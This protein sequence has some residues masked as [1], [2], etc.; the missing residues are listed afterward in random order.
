MT[1]TKEQIDRYWE[2]G[3]IVVEG[4]LSA[5]EVNELRRVTDDLVE[6]SRTVS[7]HDET[8]DLEPNHSAAAPRVRRIKMPQNVHPAYGA[9]VRHEGLL[10]IL[11]QIIGP[12]IR[13][14]NAKLNMKAP[15]GGAAVEWHQD[16]AFY[17]HTNTDL[18]AVGVMMDDCGLENGP[19]LCMPGSH[20]GPIHDHHVDGVFSGAIDPV[21]SGLDF[22]RA[23][24]CTGKAGSVSIHH[25]RMIHGSAVNTSDR[26]RRLLLYQYCAADAWPLVAL[27]QPKD[28]DEWQALM[29]CGEVDQLVPR[30]EVAP[31]RLP[32][33]QPK[34]RGSIYEVQRALKHSYFNVPAAARSA[35]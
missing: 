24:A 4:V 19:L 10:R 35:G 2:D 12:A 26:P 20:K 6:K 34:H 22:S 13:F 31:V 16:W 17:P 25:V 21:A 33:P 3:F 32:L 27:H 11:R 14:D 7:Q 15:G 30:V 29:V 9:I 8:Y 28:W 5:A 23:V 18:C 1:L